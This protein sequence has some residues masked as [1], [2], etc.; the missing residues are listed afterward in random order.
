MIF[1][2]CNLEMVG[3]HFFRRFF[4]VQMLKAPRAFCQPNYTNMDEE[5]V[6]QLMRSISDDFVLKFYDQLDSLKALCFM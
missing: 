4:P 6:V 1:D 5:G 3:R 2:Q